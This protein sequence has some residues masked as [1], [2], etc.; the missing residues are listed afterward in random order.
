MLAHSFSSD[1][2][3]VELWRLMRSCAWIQ[4]ASIK[5]QG[6]Q[7][8]CSFTKVSLSQPESHCH[9]IP[10]KCYLKLAP[11]ISSPITQLKKWNSLKG[12]VTQ[13]IFHSQEHSPQKMFYFLES[14]VT[15]N[16]TEIWEEKRYLPSKSS[17]F[18]LL[19]AFTA[20]GIRFSWSKSAFIHSKRTSNSII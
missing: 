12:K 19:W 15:M 10:S 2:K 8:Q 16:T 3:S 6:F 4:K 17:H 20:G 18:A 11:C 1:R 13:H 9:Y 7:K 14:T 5:N